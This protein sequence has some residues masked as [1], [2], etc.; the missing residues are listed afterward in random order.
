MKSKFLL[1]LLFILFALESFATTWT[2]TNSGITFTPSSLTISAGDSVLFSLMSS[3]NSLEV[4]ESTWQANGTTALNGGFETPYG[5]GL[6]TPDQLSAGTHY[7]VCAAHASLGMKGIITV[8]ST[9]ASP[10]N[11]YAGTV[12]IF[13]N[14][15][16]NLLSVK[17]T[18]GMTGKHYILTDIHGRLVHQGTITGESMTLETAELSNGIYFFSVPAIKVRAL[19]FVRE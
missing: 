10:L 15:A 8:Q 5:G 3:H 12:R 7:Y 1:Q 19:K 11:P 2:V 6:L 17:T 13:P 14:P 16:E 4:S 18:G 9:T